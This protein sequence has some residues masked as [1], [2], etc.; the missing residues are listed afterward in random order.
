MTSATPGG[1]LQGGKRA[2]VLV[3][4]LRDARAARSWALGKATGL[5][6]NTALNV[7]ELRS[8]RRGPAEKKK[9][10]AQT[11]GKSQASPD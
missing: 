7:Y 6:R 3:C 5:D 1:S 9:G 2:E 8:E 4:L 10:T 11:S